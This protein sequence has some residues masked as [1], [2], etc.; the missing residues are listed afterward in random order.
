MD[1]KDFL[2]FLH[3]PPNFSGVCRP[4]WRAAGA[5]VGAH[6]VR[7]WCAG[8]YVFGALACYTCGQKVELRDKEA[9]K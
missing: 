5:P 6:V 9:S 7:L 2:I 3:C 1:P 8:R 4:N